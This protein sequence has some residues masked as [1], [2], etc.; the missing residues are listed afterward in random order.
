[1]SQPDMVELNQAERAPRYWAEP[2]NPVEV[3]LERPAELTGRRLLQGQLN[4][5]PGPD[6]GYA[7]SLFTHLANQ[8][9]AVPGE[10][11][12]D[13]Q[14]GVVACAMALA[15]RLGRAPVQ[16]DLRLVLEHFGYLGGATSEQIQIRRDRFRGVS[17]DYQ[18]LRRM[19][20]LTE[21][22]INLQE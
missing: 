22:E 2:V 6:Q 21:M 8:L 7:L 11:L 20:A 5:R 10:Q 14:A 9:Q 4:G 16:A 3:A 18:A 19:V 15:S 12:G 13:I 1:M 17:H